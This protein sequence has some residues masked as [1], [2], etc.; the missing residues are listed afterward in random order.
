MIRDLLAGERCPRC[1]I[2]AGHPEGQIERVAIDEVLVQDCE[3]VS[4]R[5]TRCWL[6]CAVCGRL[7]AIAAYADPIDEARLAAWLRDHSFRSLPE[8]APR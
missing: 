2:L 3:G 7:W 1:N 6:Q 5:A 4:Y 8:D